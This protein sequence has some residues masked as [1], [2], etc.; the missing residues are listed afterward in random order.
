M[1]FV[2]WNLTINRRKYHKLINTVPPS[3]AEDKHNSTCKSSYVVADFGEGVNEMEVL[4]IR[5]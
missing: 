5:M 4:G 3:Q 1:Y 2:I